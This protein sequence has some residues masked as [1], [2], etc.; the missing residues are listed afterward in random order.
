MPPILRRIL[1]VLAGM[2]TGFVLVALVESAGHTIYPPP[3]DLD[4][5]DPA[6]L[7]AY[8]RS[9]P[10]GALLFVLLAWVVGTFGGAWVAAR[11]AGPQPML[12]A[13]IIGALLLAAS[14]A[15]L[16]AI[17]HP[18]WFS[19]SAVVLVPLSAWRAGRLAADSAGRAAAR[20]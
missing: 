20:T 11:L 18:V 3:K 5:T 1:A 17:P 6:A 15:N 10:L 8:V 14:V 12:H 13:G 4:F 7:N 9:I 2:V 16:I 19:V